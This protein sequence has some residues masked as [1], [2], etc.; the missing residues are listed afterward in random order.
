M[1]SFRQPVIEWINRRFGSDTLDAME[2]V[3]QKQGEKVFGTDYT[4]EDYENDLDHHEQQMVEAEQKF[5]HFND[6]RKESLE[7]ARNSSG[8]TRKRFLAEAR[9]MRKKAFR[10]VKMFA[11]H[12]EKFERKLDELTAHRTKAVSADKHA[13]VDLDETAEQVADELVGE[14][15]DRESMKR[16]EADNAID[17]ELN[18]HSLDDK[19]E[20]EEEALRKMEEEGVSADEVSL[21]DD[22][23]SFLEEELDG[24]VTNGGQNNDEDEE[25]QVV[26]DW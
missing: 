10:H 26:L 4:V 14:T 5:E 3:A 23:D 6:L 21:E 20:H 15:P 2:E 17:R 8:L 12:L 25:D 11:A 18:E 9:K 7:D 19:V 1:V 22:V 24:E 13:T 16:R